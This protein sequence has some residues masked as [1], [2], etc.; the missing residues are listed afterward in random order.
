MD[1]CYNCQMAVDPI[2]GTEAID[3]YAGRIDRWVHKCPYCGE[4][5]DKAARCPC[6]EYIHP[7]KFYCKACID[8]AKHH[9]DSM[10]KD[11][12]NV[13]YDRSSAFELICA[14]VEE[15]ANA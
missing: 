15:E 9:I 3:D 8:T 13:G 12:G 11:L 14:V 1:W 7:G 6:G 5:T 4:D 10:L 2:E